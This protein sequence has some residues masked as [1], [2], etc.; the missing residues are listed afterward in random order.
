MFISTNQVH[1]HDIIML[2][3]KSACLKVPE[4]EVIE[5]MNVRFIARREIE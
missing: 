1:Q 2:G 3:A 4:I 5:I